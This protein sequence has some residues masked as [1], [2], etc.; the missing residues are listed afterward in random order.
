MAEAQPYYGQRYHGSE[1]LSAAQLRCKE[2]ISYSTDCIDLV[3]RRVKHLLDTFKRLMYEDI[4]R[5]QSNGQ[6][7]AM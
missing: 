6:P 1:F 4:L 5:T 3:K 2:V 7:K